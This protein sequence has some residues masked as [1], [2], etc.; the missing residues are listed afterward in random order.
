MGTMLCMHICHLVKLSVVL[1]HVIIILSH[2]E[3]LLSFPFSTL[4]LDY[5]LFCSLIHFTLEKTK[6]KLEK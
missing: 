5:W 3:G 2:G 1:V 6:G 4:G